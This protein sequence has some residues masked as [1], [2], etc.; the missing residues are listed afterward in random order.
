MVCFPEIATIFLSPSVGEKVQSKQILKPIPSAPLQES[1][2]LIW[3]LVIN[4]KSNN[5]GQKLS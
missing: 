5:E 1:T 4:G 3:S 2:Q